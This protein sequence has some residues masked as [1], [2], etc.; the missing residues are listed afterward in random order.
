MQ[1]TSL[2]AAEYYGILSSHLVPMFPG[3]ELQETPI[4]DD[5]KYYVLKE[6][7]CSLLI[8]PDSEWSNCF[9]LR[10]KTSPF[11]DDDVRIAMQ[12]TRALREKLVTSEQP[13]FPYL[14][15]KCS[16]DAVAWSVQHK[17]VGDDLLPAILAMLRKWASETYEGQRISV[18]LGVDPSPDPSRISNLHLEE[19]VEQ[20][21]A[22]VLSN[23][24][25]TVLVLSPSGHVVEHLDLCEVA[26]DSG[27]EGDVWLAPRRY[28]PLANWSRGGRV[29]LTLN[30]HGEILVFTKS[31]LEFAYRNGKWAH[32][33]HSA[34]IARMGGSSAGRNLMR[35]VYATC[36]DVSFSRT[37]GC[38][39]V[40]NGRHGKK[41]LDYLN[42]DDLLSEAETGKAVL[43][44]HLTCCPFDEIPRSIREEMAALDGAIVLNHK[45]EVIA[46]G[47]IVRVPGGSDGGGRRAAAKAL[48]RLGLAIKVSS[49]GGITAF[50]DRGT[51]K[52]P[53]IAFEVCV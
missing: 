14:L 37:G 4:S 8:W 48:S 31:R 47:A 43:L 5:T 27:R 6:R 7:A 18:A 17:A 3:A 49:D 16:Q 42:R 20:D 34:M 41:Y 22:K 30:R 15:E 46:G 29:V 36:L 11:E 33:A 53:E 38:I 21:F 1:R 25:D 12:F 28:L 26:P 35:A 40:A 10:R 32:F 44:D 50:T 52:D 51:K 9:R 24:L 23:G 45:G 13:F 2:S 19:I 39:A